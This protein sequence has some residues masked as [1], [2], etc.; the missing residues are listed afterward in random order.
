M[1]GGQ[2]G[3]KTEKPTSRRI[4]KSREQGQV[5]QS[6]ELP[7][8]ASLLV[9]LMVLIGAG[10]MVLQWSAEA[11]KQGLSCNVE[12]FADMAAFSE[13]FD[14]QIVKTIVVMAPFF[15]ALFVV[16]VA[17]SVVVGG[18]TW[19]LGPL[20]WKLSA[21]SPIKGTKNMFSVKSFMKFL[22][23]V[24]KI[25]FVAAICFFY[26]REEF[27]TF[28][29]FQW[30]WPNQFMGAVAGPVVAVSFR[31][32]IAL[33]ILAAL[34]VA[35]QKWKHLK[36]L[37]MTKQEVKEEHKNQEG[38]PEIKGKRRQMQYAMAQKRMLEE[39]PQAN[40]ILVNPTHVAVAL[41]YDSASNSAPI[42]VA[43]G[44]DHLCEKIKEIGRALG[45][46]II[47]KPKLARAIFATVKVDHAIPEALF[48]AVAEVLAMI[49][50]LRN[51][52]R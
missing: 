19:S 35:F 45:V 33:F 42:V 27:E 47:R 10:P 18:M 8:V 1:A 4:K 2:A 21:I 30:L 38:S 20:K 43:K 24:G 46:A 29:T 22:L 34:D 9:L 23:S 12:C 3:E 44:G 15:M 13:F 14:A 5:V 7:A 51:G 40:V 36:D 31:I 49:Y 25:A 52:R 50:R 26:M 6:Q 11:V 16:G 41:K 37:M 39:V 28:V 17:S 32:C 48:T